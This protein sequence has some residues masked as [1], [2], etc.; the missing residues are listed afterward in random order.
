[1]TDSE[2]EQGIS[3]GRG[4]EVARIAAEKLT[5]DGAIVRFE[6]EK[7]LGGDVEGVATRFDGEIIA[8][9]NVCPHQGLPLDSYT[10]EFFGENG[11]ILVCDVHGARFEPGSGECVLG[12]CQ[13]DRLEKMRVRRDEDAGEVVILRGRGLSL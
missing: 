3:S 1:M 13:G 8:F 2:D 9:A 6:F 4:D 10:G 7:R 12:P 5:S 11:R